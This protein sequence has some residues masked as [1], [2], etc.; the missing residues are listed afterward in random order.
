MGT[1]HVEGPQLLGGLSKHLWAMQLCMHGRGFDAISKQGGVTGGRGIGPTG[2]GGT[3][4]TPGKLLAMLQSKTAF[5]IKIPTEIISLYSR[6]AYH[7]IVAELS[8]SRGHGQCLPVFLHAYDLSTDWFDQLNRRCHD[9][10]EPLARMASRELR[11]P[12]GVRV[13]P[14]PALLAPTFTPA[15]R[16]YK[17]APHLAPYACCLRNIAA[18][19]TLI[20]DHQE[21]SRSIFTLQIPYLL[22]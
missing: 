20:N 22:S 11:A 7:L 13:F 5:W 19:G 6:P 4:G 16:A 17:V 3:P 21:H 8:S 10:Q 1:A 12:P 14:L 15:N 18:S 2:L 9:V